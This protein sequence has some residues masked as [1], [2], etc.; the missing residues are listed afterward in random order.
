QAPSVVIR[1][2]P[3]LAA[4]P[5]VSIDNF[6]IFVVVGRAD[7]RIIIFIR[8]VVWIADAPDESGRLPVEFH[9]SRKNLNGE[10]ADLRVVSPGGAGGE[11]V[12]THIMIDVDTAVA[13]FAAIAI[14][15]GPIGLPK[16]I[17]IANDELGFGELLLLPFWLLELSQSGRE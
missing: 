11:I 9:V 2:A 3:V 4:V 13:V 14:L 16:A 12:P 15:E 10:F 8:R 1:L 17:D 5:I 6:P 7:R